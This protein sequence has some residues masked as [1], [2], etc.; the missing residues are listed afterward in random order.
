MERHTIIVGYAPSDTGRLALEWAIQEA[1]LRES[2]LIVVLSMWGGRKMGL[3][4]VETSRRALEE[5]ESH[6]KGKGV[7]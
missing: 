2:R 3:E 1:K 4:E 5:A 6:L 7:A